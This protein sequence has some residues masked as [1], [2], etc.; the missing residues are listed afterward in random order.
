MEINNMRNLIILKNLP[1]NLVEEAFIVL[2]KNQKIKKLEYTEGCLDRFSEEKFSESASEDY[3]VK[4]AELLVSEYINK[5]EKQDL[6][7]NKCNLKLI[8]KCKKMKWGIAVLGSIV[9]V[10]LFV[11]MCYLFAK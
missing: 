9:F 7:G 8:K 6:G 2:K 1:S 3:I 5:L 11:T 4:E 10:N